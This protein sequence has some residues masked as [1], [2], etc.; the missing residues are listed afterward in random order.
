MD[1][2]RTAK[3]YDFGECGYEDYRVVFREDG[4]DVDTRHFSDFNEVQK[5]VGDWVNDGV[6]PD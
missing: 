4:E 2:T 1:M 6:L 3:W 5:A